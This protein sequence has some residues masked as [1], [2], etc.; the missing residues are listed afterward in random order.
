MTEERETHALTIRQELSPSIWEMFLQIDQA[1]YES[2]KF[3]TTR[4]ET[5]IKLIFCLENGLPLSAANTGLYIVNGR[6]GIM[7]N[8]IASKIRMHPDYDYRIDKL[9][10]KGC[11]ITILRDNIVEIGQVTFDES[12]AK[13]A[14]LLSKTNWECYPED[15]YFNRAISR[16]YKLHCPDIFSQPVYVPEEL[17]GTNAI[18]GEWSVFPTQYE[19]PT[20]DDL[21]QLYS[22]E[23]IMTANDGRIPGT[24]EEV[25]A[26]AEKLEAATMKPEGAE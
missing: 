7:G 9:T 12:M 17:D 1:T 4:G 16:A 11:T 25:K 8:I 26:V 21:L 10:D 15:M 6:L 20:L 5:A 23:A 14:D 22:A 18:D 24:D 3:K 2:R 13:R 19:E